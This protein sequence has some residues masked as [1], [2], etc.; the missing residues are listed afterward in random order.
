MYRRCHPDPA[1]AGEGSAFS[2]LFRN[3]RCPET[4]PG[5]GFAALIM[6]GFLFFRSLFGKY[7]TRG[8]FIVPDRRKVNQFDSDSSDRT[9]FR[10]FRESVPPEFD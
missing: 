7:G 2:L 6:T 4:P 8:K 1:V 10:Q 5:R 9:P 3:G